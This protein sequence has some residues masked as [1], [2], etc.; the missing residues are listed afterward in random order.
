MERE[1]RSDGRYI[2]DTASS[3]VLEE[4]VE[5]LAQVEARLEVGR[6]QPRRLLRRQVRRRLQVRRPSVV[7]LHTYIYPSGRF[8]GSCPYRDIILD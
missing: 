5:Q 8:I 6:H 2:N 3:G 1:D 7:H 4:R